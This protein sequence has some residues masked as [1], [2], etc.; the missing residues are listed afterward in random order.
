MSPDLHQLFDD[1]GRT[2]PR[3]HWAADDVVRR[4]DALRR[5]RGVVTVTASV[6]ATALVVAAAALLASPATHRGQPPAAS[7][8]RPTATGIPTV[9]SPTP[10][11]SSTTPTVTA[12][13][14]SEITL[15][16][17]T[18]G[19]AAGTSYRSVVASAGAGGSCSLD[20]YPTVT[21]ANAAGRVVGPPAMRDQVATARRIVIGTGR[22]SFLLGFTDTANFDPT[23]CSPVPVTTL[24][25]ALS[26]DPTVISL[27]L[28]AGTLT[29]SRD[30]SALGAP[31]VAGPWVA[32]ST[33][34]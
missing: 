12:C 11:S 30:V 1:A 20:G 7:S 31:L 23:A 17:G 33:G 18:G 32:G 13:R 34:Q 16:L 3:A 25:V 27:D 10:S 19:V 24:R 26:G 8:E 29:C 9:G 22:A 21:L 4:G 5:R 6:A 2:P 14:A 28:P 15:A